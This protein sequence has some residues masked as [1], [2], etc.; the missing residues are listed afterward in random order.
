ME[1]LAVD[2]DHQI[3]AGQAR[4]IVGQLLEDGPSFGVEGQRFKG[5]VKGEGIDIPVEVFALEIDFEA[6]G[7]LLRRR[8][9][10]ALGRVLGCF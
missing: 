9:N 10:V 3:A 7:H 8:V 1:G 4:P 5:L 2:I 6:S